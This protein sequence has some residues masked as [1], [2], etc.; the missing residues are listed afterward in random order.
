M[1]DVGRILM[2]SAR[3]FILSHIILFF[4]E[5]FFSFFLSHIILFYLESYYS[6]FSWIKFFF[7]ESISIFLE[8]CSSSLKPSTF[9]K[10]HIYV[11]VAYFR[12]TKI[13][14]GLIT[15][16]VTVGIVVSWGFPS[17]N[18]RFLDITLKIFKN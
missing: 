3:I 5:S 10:K 14:F 2:N 16:T 18:G 9:S 1:I 6:L 12:K 4:I 17:L 15:G 13:Y 11:I 8:S 7:L